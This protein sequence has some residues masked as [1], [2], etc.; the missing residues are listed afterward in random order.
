MRNLL[1]TILKMVLGSIVALVL[2]LGAARASIFGEENALLGKIFLE[3][4]QQTLR[5]KDIISFAS[6]EL[7]V[8]N[9]KYGYEKWINKGLDQV[10]DYGFLD[11]IKTDDYVLGTLQYNLGNVGF[12]MNGDDYTLGQFD[13]W[14]DQ[15]WGKAP[16][17]LN[18]ESKYPGSL[19]EWQFQQQNDLPGLFLG[20]ST[21][22]NMVNRQNAQLSY[23]H[24][25]W[26]MAY[27][28]KIKQTY[29][30]LLD[31]AQS[32]NPGEASRISAQSNALQNIQL[33]R[34]DN[35]Q[36]AILKLMAAKQL[37]NLQSQQHDA[38]SLAQGLSSVGKLFTHVPTFL[39]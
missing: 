38:Q 4:M 32:S 1:K 30:D 19:S 13:E 25:L 7:H 26:N 34:L 21:M 36:S 2:L 28:D 20:S 8:L 15:V 35:T 16:E 24:A 17:L 9:Q 18:S 31:D 29:E 23:K 39:K 5:L 3:D 14:V 12:T 37:S 10:K 27:N 6:K 22:S 33:G 11:H